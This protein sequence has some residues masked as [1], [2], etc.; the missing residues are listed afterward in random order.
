MALSER[1]RMVKRL[2]DETTVDVSKEHR[3]AHRS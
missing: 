3:H 1:G 2:I